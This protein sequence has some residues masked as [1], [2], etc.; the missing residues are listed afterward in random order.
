MSYFESEIIKELIVGEEYTVR[1][2][3]ILMQEAKDVLIISKSVPQLMNFNESKTVRVL[4]K[5]EAYTHRYD[6]QSYAHII[7]N[8]KNV[9]Y[10]VE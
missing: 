7:P 2:L 4:D 5:I 8:S 6:R 1:Q 9:T 3:R 10:I